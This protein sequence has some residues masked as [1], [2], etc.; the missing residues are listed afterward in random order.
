MAGD[1]LRVKAA[2]GRIGVLPGAVGAHREVGHR[3]VVP[4]VRKTADDREAGPAVRAGDERVAV[5]PV[6]RIGQF[7]ETCLA[8]RH[9]RRDQGA[10][11]A[12][13]RGGGDDEPVTS[14]GGD[15]MVVDGLH[16]RERRRLRPDTVAEQGDVGGRSLD[17]RDNALTGVGHM[18]D[19]VEPRGERVQERPE[20]D[21]LHHAPD[22][23]P[24]ALHRLIDDGDGDAGGTLRT[25]HEPDC[26]MAPEAAARVCVP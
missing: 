2:V 4:V 10:R 14:G 25:A 24:P 9:V 8:G 22:G 23:D 12:S 18:A 20:P 15:L 3:R 1:R 26:A 11:G 6:G 21:A 7:G 13:G 17:F 19:Q 5:T 16:A